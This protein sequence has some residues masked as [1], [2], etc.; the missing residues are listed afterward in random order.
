MSYDQI[1]EFYD[2]VAARQSRS[3]GPALADVLRGLPVSQAPLVEIGAGTGRVTRTIAAALADVDIIAVEPSPS[4]RAV[5]TSR[6]W[7]DPT[8]RARVTVSSGWAPDLDLPDSILGAVVFGVAG[9]LEEPQ[10][11]ELWRRLAERLVPGGCLVVELMGSDRPMPPTRTVHETVGR[12]TY[13]WWVSAEPVRDGVVRHVNWWRV[14]DGDRVCREVGDEHVWHVIS[15][16][17][18][19]AESGLRARPAGSDLVVLEA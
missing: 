19:A 4:M 10:R 16:E 3:T 5:L 14:L 9:H 12:L 17:Q 1:A 6:V 15:P 8:L 18:L 2:L 11:T 7:A 13:E